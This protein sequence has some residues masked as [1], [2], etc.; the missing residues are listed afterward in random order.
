MG[1]FNFWKKDEDEAPKAEDIRKEVED[2]GLD[3]EG[4]EIEVEGDTVKVKGTPKDAE[5]RE[6][7]ILAA[8][9]A[10]GVAKVEDDS[11]EEPLFHTVAKGE[12][13]WKIAEKHLGNGA[14]YTEIFEANKPMLSDPDKIYPGQVLRIPRDAQ[15]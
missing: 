12:N 9:N 13:L 7:I 3:T 1:L 4:V 15:A 10:A 8:G 11:A 6:K 2:L 5:T 14:R